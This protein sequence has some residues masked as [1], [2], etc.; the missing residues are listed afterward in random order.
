MPC[1]VSATISCTV[2]TSQPVHIAVIWERS[3]S[4]CCASAP[5]R[6]KTNCAYAALSTARRLIRPPWKNGRPKARVLDFAMTVL[7][8]S[9]NAAA[10]VTV[11][12]CKSISTG[13]QTFPRR[14]HPNGSSTVAPRLLAGPAPS[15]GLDGVAVLSARSP[16]ARPLVVSTDDRLLDDLL[17]VLAAAGADP[18]LAT[19]GPAPRPAPP[20]GPPGVGGADPPAAPA[21]AAPAP[22]PAPGRGSAG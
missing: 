22:P 10:R 16:S 13:R 12:D 21:P 1:S 8:R 7:S 18:E 3:R 20:A 17:R 4:I 15:A 5:C 6:E 2:A 14:P 11:H 9:K 19:G